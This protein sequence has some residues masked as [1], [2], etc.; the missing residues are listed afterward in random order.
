MLD[1]FGE[2]R[3]G[4]RSLGLEIVLCMCN[5]RRDEVVGIHNAIRYELN[6]YAWDLAN[7]QQWVN[8]AVR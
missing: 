2:L 5:E 4:G 7:M 6:G 8:L 3:S 1:H